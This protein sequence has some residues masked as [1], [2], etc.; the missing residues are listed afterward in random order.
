MTPKPPVEQ[1]I[2]VPTP[3][4]EEVNSVSSEEIIPEQPLAEEGQYTDHLLRGGGGKAG[5]ACC[6]R[7]T[8]SD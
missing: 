3:L 6:N 7:K 2:F 4:E 5:Q 1:V 8:R